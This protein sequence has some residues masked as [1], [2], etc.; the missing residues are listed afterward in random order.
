MDLVG[1]ILADLKSF[2]GWNAIYRFDESE[3]GLVDVVK[4][5]LTSDYGFLDIVLTKKD[6]NAIV[7][8][9]SKI[10]KNLRASEAQTLLF[11]TILHKAGIS[12]DDDFF[13]D[14]EVIKALNGKAAESKKYGFRIQVVFDDVDDISLQHA[15]NNLICTRRFHV[16]AYQSLKKYPYVTSNGFVLQPTHDFSSYVSDKYSKNKERGRKSIYD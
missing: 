1:K 3:E 7:L 14:G 15:I 16:M 4:K 9:L 11:R 13:F 8:E 12:T 2:C 6:C 5:L 10:D